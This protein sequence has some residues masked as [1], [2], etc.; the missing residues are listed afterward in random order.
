LN[1]VD[2]AAIG[3]V[4]LTMLLGYRSGFISGVMGLVC[5]TAGIGALILLAPFGAELLADVDPFV[6]SLLVLLAVALALGVGE[7]VGGAIASVIRR[8]LGRGILSAVDQVAGAVLGLAQ[9]VFLVWLV[10][11]L[12]TA[13]PSPT[14]AAEARRSVLL[15]EVDRRLPSPI[16]VIAELGRAL[17]TS[18][19][20]DVFL[21]P[22]PD[23][24]P[25]V[26]GPL[27]QEA[28]RI[29]AA[30]AVS[31]VRIEAV[32]CGR[33]LSGTG[34]ALG[35]EH[36]VTNAHVVAGASQVEI[37][38]DGRFDRFDATVVL[39]DPDLDLAVL[40]SPG[41]MH[42]PLELART[43]PERGDRG[44][45]LGHTG[46]GGVRVIPA[47]VTR[48]IPAIGRDIY[49]T[50]RVTRDMLEL[51]AG[52]SPGDSG[53]PLVLADGSVGGVIFSE[54][55]TDTAVGYALTA[56]SVAEVAEPA[57]DEVAPVDLGPCAR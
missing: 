15:N 14:I 9:G 52:V 22:A 26:S 1:L 17:E 29:A 16:G 25:P 33:L 31:V 8:R 56:E 19:L 36:V 54:A 5:A 18:L 46:G 50:G 48:H 13:V 40:R 43:S 32:A 2:V 41:L 6:R 7:S 37:S 44:A 20:P 47:A 10:G 38:Q 51:Q 49:G 23:P 53:G 21:G 30:A 45:A 35:E 39:F 11:G 55:R 12:V 42:V 27:R 24:A 34:F 57:L 4:V 3:L 28:E